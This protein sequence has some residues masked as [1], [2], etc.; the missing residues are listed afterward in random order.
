MRGSPKIGGDPL[1]YE[2]IP[3]DM[4]GSPKIGGDPLRL[5]GIP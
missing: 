2:E 1:R 5:V 4:R 3:K